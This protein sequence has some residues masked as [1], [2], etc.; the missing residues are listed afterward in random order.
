VDA[1]SRALEIYRALGSRGNEAWALNHYAAAISA[2][3]DT[4]RAL[5]LYQQALA[6]NREQNKP[7][8]EA[9]A[10]E[11]LG[12]CHLSAGEI[13]PGVARLRQALGIYRRLGM[14]ADTR[15]V[16]DRLSALATQ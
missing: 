1:I 8:Y 4:P 15:R 6:M 10:L 2:T 16:Q 5:A 7:N 14:A 9:V 11:G 12:E 13:E 3:G